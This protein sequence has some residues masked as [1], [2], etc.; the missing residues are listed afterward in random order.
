MYTYVFPAPHLPSTPAARLSFTGSPAQFFLCGTL[1][2]MYFYMCQ[3]PL[4]RAL[5]CLSPHSSIRS[6]LSCDL[7]V[8]LA[9]CLLTHSHRSTL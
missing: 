1:L 7:G 5:I 3:R 9:R 2:Y 8:D 4:Y 6:L